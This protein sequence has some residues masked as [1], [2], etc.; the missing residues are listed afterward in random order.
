MWFKY[1]K[2]IFVIALAVVFLV[3]LFLVKNKT[4]IKNVFTSSVQEES[5]GLVFDTEPLSNLISK[6]TDKDGIVDWEENLWGTNPQKKDTNDDGV[7]DAQEIAKLKTEQGL[8]N[9]EGESSLTDE[10]NLTKTEQFSREL[11]ATVATLSQNGGV[12]QETIDKIGLSLAEQVKNTPV[13]K[14]YKLSDLKI[15]KDESVLAV[16]NYQ[17]T[18]NSIYAKSTSTRTVMDVLQDFLGDGENT[19]ASVLEELDPINTQIK[20]VIDS[21]VKMNTPASL[22]SLHLDMINGLQK[23]SENIK[24][25]KLFETDTIVALSAV[26]QYEENTELLDITITKLL[27]TINQKL[28]N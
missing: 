8:N 25:V 14:V 4:S 12:D 24:N 20:N 23:L 27:D 17:N 26:S 11:I 18:M 1:K 21:L 19:N 28:N 3:V 9:I 5:D 13:E 15:T 16:Q 6:D 10:K 22:A 7:G 2:R